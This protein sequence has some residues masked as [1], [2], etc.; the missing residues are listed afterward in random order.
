[1]PGEIR[2]LAE[3]IGTPIDE[4]NGKLQCATVVSII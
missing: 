4:K 2:R 1:M 3:L